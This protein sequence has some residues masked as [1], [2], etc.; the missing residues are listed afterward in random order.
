MDGLVNLTDGFQG[1]KLEGSGDSPMSP[2]VFVQRAQ[3]SNI[4]AAG[5]L[6]LRIARS[7][8]E[9]CRKARMR[10]RFLQ[11]NF[12]LNRCI[13]REEWTRPTHSWIAQQR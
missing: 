12:A 13:A 3:P 2:D 5:P 1:D 11:W 4:S 10:T 6:A 8:L 9:E 7:S